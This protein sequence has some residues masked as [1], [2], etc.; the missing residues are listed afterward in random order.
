VPIPTPAA[1]KLQLP[2]K[3]KPIKKPLPQHNRGWFGRRLT[4]FVRP[5]C[6]GFCLCMGHGLLA[7]PLLSVL[8][9]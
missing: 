1:I 8:M 3:T 7:K 9:A 4:Y 5:V 6:R 2:D